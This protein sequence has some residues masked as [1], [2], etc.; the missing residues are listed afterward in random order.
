MQAGCAERVAATLCN[1][2]SARGDHVTLMPTFS[3]HYE[4]FYE[5]SPGIILVC[6]AD[7]VTSRVRSLVSQ[8]ERIKSLCGHIEK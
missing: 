6:L 1:R 3:R 4:C 8:L 5:L 7:L 2:W